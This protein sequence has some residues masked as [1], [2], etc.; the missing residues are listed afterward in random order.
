MAL[1]ARQKQA[2]EQFFTAASSLSA[3]LAS[4]NVNAFNEQTEKL[5]PALT[6]LDSAFPDGHPW[7]ADIKKVT[8]A[9]HLEKAK[10]LA[11]ARTSFIPFTKAAAEFAKTARSQQKAFASIKIYECPMAPKPGET[12]QWVQLKAPLRNPFY[13]SEMLECG[14]EVK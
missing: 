6:N 2:T 12:T 7:K 1:D 14:N 11:D 10:T 3:S 5:Q 4:D 9:S 8:R 13:G